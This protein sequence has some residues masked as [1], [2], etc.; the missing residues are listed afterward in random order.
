[1]HSPRAYLARA[2]SASAA[3]ERSRAK[4]L[5]TPSA[6]L[7]A[8]HLLALSAFAIAQ[9]M[10]SLLTKQPFHLAIEGFR[11]VVARSPGDTEAT[12]LLGRA[13]RH[14]TAD[15]KA[16]ARERLKTNYDEAAY[17]QLQAELVK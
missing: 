13:L 14:D 10:F 5:A 16:D 6:R 4:Y 8:A 12:T 2:G 9:P 1:M 7:R 11:A 3:V 17:R 15:P